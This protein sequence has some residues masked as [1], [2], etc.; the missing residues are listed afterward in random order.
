ML[1]MFEDGPLVE[2]GKRVMPRAGGGIHFH[3]NLPRPFAGGPVSWRLV[4][5]HHVA[6]VLGLL[7]HVEGYPYGTRRHIAEPPKV[8]ADRGPRVGPIRDSDFEVQLRD[9]DA[10]GYGA[11]AAPLSAIM[12]R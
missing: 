11:K 9:M 12:G 6:R 10:P 7:V 3:K 8:A 2:G 4:A 1:G 5:L